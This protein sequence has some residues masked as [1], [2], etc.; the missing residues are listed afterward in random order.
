LLL[1]KQVHNRRYLQMARAANTYRG[2]NTS[3]V[4]GRGKLRREEI[5][6]QRQ[7]EINAVVQDLGRA[8]R[9]TPEPIEEDDQYTTPVT[10]TIEETATERKNRLARERRATKK[11]EA[12]A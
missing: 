1:L 3:K 9:A 7:T 5:R 11:M 2:N 6:I 12:V 4:A 10:E 8:L